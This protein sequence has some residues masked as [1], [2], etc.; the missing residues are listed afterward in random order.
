MPIYV[1]ECRELHRHEQHRPMSESGRPQR[2]PQCQGEARQIVVGCNGIVRGG[3]LGQDLDYRASLGRTFPTYEALDQHLEAKG[4]FMGSKQDHE[5]KR[6]R[7]PTPQVPT[8]DDVQRAVKETTGRSLESQV[9]P[10]E[11]VFGDDE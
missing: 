4:L 11:S 9:E 8:M 5:R 1:Y 7:A 10:G 6:G 2:C 3:T